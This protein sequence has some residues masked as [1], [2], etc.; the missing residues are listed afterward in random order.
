MVFPKARVQAKF[1][2]TQSV[3]CLRECGSAIY[4][5]NGEY[6]RKLTPD[7]ID[8]FTRA[9][10]GIAGMDPDFSKT[11]LAGVLRETGSRER[12]GI[13]IIAEGF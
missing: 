8:L 3:H 1:G 7:Q 12:E 2:S 13:S 11:A 4:I 10:T 5:Q 6:S 9:F